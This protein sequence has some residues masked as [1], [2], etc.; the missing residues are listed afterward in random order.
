[1]YIIH[2][3]VLS[4]LSLFHIS[5]IFFLFLLLAFFFVVLFWLLFDGSSLGILISLLTF[6]EIPFKKFESELVILS[7]IKGELGYDLEAGVSLVPDKAL[8]VLRRIY[9]QVDIPIRKALRRHTSLQVL[10]QQH[11]VVAILDINLILFVHYLL[12]G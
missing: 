5:S 9:L 7:R 3:S 8:L 10:H 12:F 11:D 6:T 2:I 1:M 4:L